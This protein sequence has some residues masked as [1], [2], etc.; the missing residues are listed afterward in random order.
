MLNCHISSLQHPL[1]GLPWIIVS[2]CSTMAWFLAVLVVLVSGHAGGP[3]VKIGESIEGVDIFCGRLVLWREISRTCNYK[4]IVTLYTAIWFEISLM[5]WIDKILYWYELLLMYV[6]HWH[7]LLTYHR[8]ASN[9][10][11]ICR[12]FD[13]SLLAEFLHSLYIFSHVGLSRI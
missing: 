1:G 3:R 12:G 4:K 11:S 5:I 10:S 13:A 8:V 6:H 2:P 9:G 7:F